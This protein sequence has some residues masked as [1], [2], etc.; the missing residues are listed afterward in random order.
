VTG[1]TAVWIV[2]EYQG[3]IPL[4]AAP[5]QSPTG[6]CEGGI[7]LEPL[8]SLDAFL[9]GV[10]RRALRMAEL[11]TGNPDD[12][13]DLVQDAMTA[14]VQRYRHREPAQWGPLF[15]R[16]LQNRIRDWARRTSVRRRVRAWLG[17]PGQA[18]D[19]DNPPPDPIQ[20]MPDPAGLEMEDRLQQ[21]GAMEQL[22]A[23]LQGL[24]RRQQ[25]AFLLRAWEGLD[26]NQTAFAMGCSA[27][28]VKTHYSRA[29]HALRQQLEGHWP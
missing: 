7:T 25:Q 9:A 28:S 10:E 13:L 17:R 5:R 21:E 27:G 1:S 6:L 16:I 22:V 11:A 29:V 23:A 2:A 14:L 20:A 18:S 19:P 4:S 24:P 8:D 15:Y 3:I 26:V 12:A